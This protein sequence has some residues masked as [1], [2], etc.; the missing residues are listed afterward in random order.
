MAGGFDERGIAA[1]S[2]ALELAEDRS[3]AASSIRIAVSR[4][5]AERLDDLPTAIAH[6]SAV[7]SDAP[8]APVARGLEGRWRARLGD[9]AGA[10]LAFARLRE[11]AASLSPSTDDASIAATAALLVEAAHIDRTLL[12][13]P[14]GAQRHL[15]VALR[16]RPHD[17]D[18]RRAYREVGAIVAGVE[19]SD[20][21]GGLLPPADTDSAAEI[22]DAAAAPRRAFDFTL[23]SEGEVDEDDGRGARVEELTRRLHANPS[24]DA[25]ADELASLLE[26]LGRGHELLALLSA[27]LEDASPSRRDALAP[28]AHAALVRLAE[29]A[30]AAG[31]TEEAALYRSA[32]AAFTP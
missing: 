18:L 6:V 12:N 15:A 29:Q 4:A 21:P 11:L 7:P 14:L 5:L 10:S 13:D 9:V 30:E 3:E 1:L 19:A 20:A 24:D 27:R 17:V 8:E 25:V 22:D 2:R 26:G 31:R 28:R 32:L 16:L 23:P